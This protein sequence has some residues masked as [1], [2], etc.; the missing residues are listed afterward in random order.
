MKIKVST[1]LAFDTEYTHFLAQKLVKKLKPKIG[2]TKELGTFEISGIETESLNKLN[3]G[4]NLYRLITTST[5][6]E[7][8]EFFQSPMKVTQLVNSESDDLNIKMRAAFNVD[9][10]GNLTIVEIDDMTW[11]EARYKYYI[12]DIYFSDGKLIKEI[13]IQIV[14]EDDLQILDSAFQDIEKYEIE[15]INIIEESKLN[16]SSC[17][18]LYQ[19]SKEDSLNSSFSNNKQYEEILAKEQFSLSSRLLSVKFLI[20]A[21][22]YLRKSSDATITKFLQESYEAFLFNKIDPSMAKQHIFSKLSSWGRSCSD[23]TLYAHMISE[24]RYE[25]LHIILYY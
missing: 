18:G 24:F 14:D 23:Q 6:N 13:Y 8:T 22:T 11:L 5:T 20:N 25:Y 1:F 12:A 19:R 7:S 16:S 10:M 2:K 9:F 21:A 15:K 17:S 4:T 3:N